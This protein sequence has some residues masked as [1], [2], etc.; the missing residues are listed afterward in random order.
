MN[1]VKIFLEYITDKKFN[2]VEEDRKWYLNNIYD[3]ENKIRG[4]DNK[5][6]RNIDILNL[7]DSVRKIFVPPNYDKID[8]EQSDATDMP[9]LKTEESTKQEEGQRLKILT[10]QQMLSRLPILVAQL[11]AGNNLQKLKNETRQLL[12]SLYR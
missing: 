9:E 12:Y 1:R 3:Q 2:N 5:N 11:Q 7:Y 6:N 10:P 4:V 8:D